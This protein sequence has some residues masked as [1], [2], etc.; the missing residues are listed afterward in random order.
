MKAVVALSLLLLITGL[1]A[2]CGSDSETTAIDTSALEGTPWVLESGSGGITPPEGVALSAL[3]DA[4]SLSGSA[5]CNRFT[6]SYTVD[7]SAMS[8]GT[9]ATTQIACPPPLDVVEQAYLAA[10]GKVAAWT[11]D[12]GA[13]VLSDSGGAELLR[14]TAATVTGDWEVNAFLR[15]NGFSTPVA[16]TTLTATFTEDGKLAGSAGCNRYTGTYTAD[17]GTITITPPA[18][19]KKLCTE[20]EDVMAQEAAYLAVLPTATGYQLS[21]KTLDLLRADGT[22]VVSFTPAP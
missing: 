3:F 21:G 17:A 9:I 8:I 18:S 20:P 7:A 14:Y 2:G 12:A 15:G 11:V 19:T 4:G 16:G 5:G 6:A 13:L 1:S 10:L 22:R